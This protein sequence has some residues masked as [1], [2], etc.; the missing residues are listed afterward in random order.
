MIT[1]QHWIQHITFTAETNA[2]CNMQSTCD[3]GGLVNTQ[4]H[5]CQAT[6]YLRSLS[7]GKGNYVVIYIY[8]VS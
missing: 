8:V 6:Q 4:T 5:R 3:I 1:R 7:G 2:A